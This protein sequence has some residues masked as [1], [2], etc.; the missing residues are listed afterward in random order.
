MV[1]QLERTDRQQAQPSIEQ[2]WPRNV[3]WL[4]IALTLVAV[5]PF[6][7]VR[8]PVMTDYPDHLARWFV[9]FHMNDT[10]YH[11]AGFYASAWDPLPYISPDVLAM[12]LQYFL[13]IDIVG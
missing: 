4:L 10:A 8:Y 3:S 7:T 13:P 1:R 2:T 12:V 6:W 9:L 11:F 5:L